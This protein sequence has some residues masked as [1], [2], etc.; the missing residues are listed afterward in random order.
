MRRV[1]A[2]GQRELVVERRREH[3]YIA[4]TSAEGAGVRSTR[5]QVRPRPARQRGAKSTCT[6]LIAAAAVLHPGLG[7]LD[8]AAEK[9]PSRESGSQ[10]TRRWRKEDS[11]PRSLLRRFRPSHCS[12]PSTTRHLRPRRLIASIWSVWICTPRATDRQD[13]SQ[14]QALGRVGRGGE[15]AAN[16]GVHETTS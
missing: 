7:L 8:K 1:K 11:N 5:I 4:T 12:G 14:P 6:A 15:Q 3:Q 9:L 16:A 10:Q 13:H 2:R